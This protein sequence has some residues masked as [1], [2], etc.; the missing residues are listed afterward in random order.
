MITRPYPPVELRE[1]GDEFA[2]AFDLLEW[3][4]SSFIDDGA[5]LQNPDHQHLQAAQIGCLWTN[6]AN[7]KQMRQVIGQAERPMPRGSKW[8]IARQEMQLRQWFGQEPDFLI[9]I[10]APAIMDF[11][12]SSWCALIEHELYHCSQAQDEYG[13]LKYRN[14][15]SPIWALRGHDVEE[16]IGVVERYGAGAASDRVA[17]IA[18]AA[19]APPAVGRHSISTACGTCQLRLA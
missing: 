17:E 9:T 7:A 3:M 13:V 6:V 1:P 2:T 15:G 8:Q 12:D 10:Y 14:D 5:V 18:R 11:D 19:S 16:F 4:T